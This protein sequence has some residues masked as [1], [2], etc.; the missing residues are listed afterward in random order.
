MNEASGYVRDLGG[1]LWSEAKKAKRIAADD[2]E[3]GRAFGLYEAVSLMEQQAASFG[4]SPADVG[5]EGRAA[6]AL[7]D[8]A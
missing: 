3:R 2:F 4:L 8:Q 7:L 1:L 5:L 6:D